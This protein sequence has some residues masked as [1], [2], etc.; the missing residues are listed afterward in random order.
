[1]K[2]PI[3]P[4][5]TSDGLNPEDPRKFLNLWFAV[6][7]IGLFLFACFYTLKVAVDLFLPIVLAG[8]LGF[9]LTPVTRWL[10]QIGLSS[11]WA[12]LLGTLGFLTILI[13]LFAALYV[14]LARFEP[15]FPRYLDH[16]QERLMPILQAIQKSSPSV[17][18]IGACSPLLHFGHADQ[19]WFRGECLDLCRFARTTPSVTLGCRRVF[20]PLHSLHRIHG[21]H[22]RYDA[23]F[24]DSF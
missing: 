17:D 6:A 7:V 16:I 2:H 11:F 20:A 12:S 10:R 15:D 13:C 9:L 4:K 19:C 22:R 3:H 8:F 18:R 24:I 21:W 1:M 14:S 5:D 23:C